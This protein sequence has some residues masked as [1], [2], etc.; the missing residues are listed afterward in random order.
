[1]KYFARWF[2]CEAFTHS[3]YLPCN[4]LKHVH[5]QNSYLLKMCHSTQMKALFTGF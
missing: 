5:F 4:Q 3:V 2:E 1:M